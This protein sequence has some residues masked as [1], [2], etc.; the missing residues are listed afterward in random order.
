MEYNNKIKSLSRN[1][2]NLNEGFYNV[3]DS[4]LNRANS[5]LSQRSDENLD[6]IHI[7]S[8]NFEPK[9][10]KIKNSNISQNKKSDSKDQFD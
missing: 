4:N 6:I 10:H 5:K 9:Y 1:S 8:E 7:K 2:N 3:N